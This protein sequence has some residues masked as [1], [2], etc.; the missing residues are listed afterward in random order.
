MLFDELPGLAAMPWRALAHL[1][2]PVESCDAIAPWLGRTGV[3]MKR[4]DL[5]SPLYGGNK[6]RRFEFVLADAE[7]RD[8]KRIVTT[9]GIAST[10]VMATATFGRACGF[11]VRAVLFDQP[12]THFARRAVLADVSLG[13]ELVWGGGYATTIARTLAA[14]HRDR[15]NYFVMPGASDPMANLGYLDAMLELD[16]QVRAGELPRPDVIVVPSGSSGTLAALALGAAYLGWDTEIVGVRIT[17]WIACNRLTVSRV[18]HATSRF[19]AQRDPRWTRRALRPRWSIHHS[20]IGEGYGY[21]TR[22]SVEAIAQVQTLIGTP[23][24]VTYTG[25]ALVGLRA[26]AHE[27]RFRGKTLLL[28]NT[29]S[30]VSPEVAP[31]A[32]ARVPRSLEWMFERPTVA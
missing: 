32:R 18:L 12:L 7:A 11:A 13:A 5:V 21:P 15:G 31:D 19:V 10:Q 8:R 16:A 3:F 2:T 14:Y 17:A 20:A 24:E 28:W 1:P 23:G 6:V 9:G 22:E 4:D 25:K 27:E 29:L 26:L 30:A